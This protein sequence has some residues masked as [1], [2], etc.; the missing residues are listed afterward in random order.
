MPYN[1][2]SILDSVKKSI[3]L[4][5]DQTHFD[6][7]LIMHINS[8]FMYLNQLG[9]GPDTIYRITDSTDLWSDFMQDELEGIRSFVCL[10][11]RSIFDPPQQASLNQALNDNLKE[12]EWR[13]NYQIESS[14]SND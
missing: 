5:Y 9:V 4:N 11:V 2:E 1:S 7:D 6:S 3:G 14:D 8:V 10:K 13:L 12:L